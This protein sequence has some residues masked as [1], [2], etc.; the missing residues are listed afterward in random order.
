MR[1][2]CKGHHVCIFRPTTFFLVSNSR[3]TSTYLSKTIF[4]HIWSTQDDQ[5]TFHQNDANLDITARKYLKIVTHIFGK[6]ISFLFWG[7][8]YTL[9]VYIYI[10]ILTLIYLY[11]PIPP[12]YLEQWG[13]IPII[14]GTE[15]TN[16]PHYPFIIPYLSRNYSSKLYINIYLHISMCAI[17]ETIAVVGKRPFLGEFSFTSPSNICWR[18]YIP[19][20]LGDV[21]HWDINPNPWN[22]LMDK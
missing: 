5:I 15:R 3:E 13:H 17:F 22:I 9:Y 20:Q 6:N 4:A 19:C 18:W 7:N 11:I 21:K 10:N 16:N 12:K 1:K 2:T 14:V 8:T